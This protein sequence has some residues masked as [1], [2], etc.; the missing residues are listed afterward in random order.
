MRT[1]TLIDSTLCVAQHAL[2]GGRATGAMLLP[3]LR[4]MGAAGFGAIDILDGDVHEVAAQ[5]LKEH[6]WQRLRAAA[7]CAPRAPLSVWARGRCMFGN[8]PLVDAMIALAIRRLAAYG[9]RRL[10][11]Y[12]PL[13][14]TANLAVP[15][16]FAREAGLQVCGAIVY[17]PSPAQPVDFY[18]DRARMLVAMD[19]D[20][21]CL[22]DPAGTLDPDSARDT[23][24][25]LRIAIGDRPLEV[26][27]H[28][29]SGVAEIAYLESV[30][31][32]ADV[33]HTAAGPLAG[34]ASLPPAEYCAENLPRSGI[35]VR[36]ARAELA[37]LADYFTA[38]AE[39][40]DFSL[41][42]HM[43]R[44]FDA[45]AHQL[46]GPTLAELENDMIKSEVSARLS[47]ALADVARIRAEL[48][49]PTM[50]MPI[51]RFVCRQALLNLRDGRRYRSLDPGIVRYL[52]GAYGTPPGTIDNELRRRGRESGVADTD[53]SPAMTGA[54]P[55]AAQP[56]TDDDLLVVAMC[57][58]E[59]FDA[60][61]SRRT[62]ADEVKPVS[63]DT[64]FD[65]LVA[66]LE[67]RQWVRRIAVR[68]GTFAFASETPG[69]SERA[70]AADR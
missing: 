9:V 39:R 28:C 10:T 65:Q 58:T 23:V 1:V 60:L 5:T 8:A 64:P 33:L 17:A 16:R 36:P 7:K 50:T 22:W 55:A 44:D 30:R 42:T 63:A 45:L 61:R 34:S 38:L 37:A 2:W 69:R 51:G 54:R 20:S 27:G 53:A 62:D 15:I 4:R 6:P 68:K 52:S 43:L 40:H 48:G 24:S 67:R 47:D 70:G 46:P 11:C 3:I 41:G 14:D 56:S 31:A 32:G 35:A 25:V 18:P 19:V 12:D 21:V 59:I 57:G 26:R 66:E 13:N 49:F 29:R